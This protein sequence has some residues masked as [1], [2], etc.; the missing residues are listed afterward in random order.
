VL[1]QTGGCYAR[2]GNYKSP[3]E[4]RAE[5]MEAD[6]AREREA[7]ERLASAEL[8]MEFQAILAEP[9]G[10]A[11]QGLFAALNNYEKQATGITKQVALRTAFRASRGLPPER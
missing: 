9:A 2:P 3:A 10:A 1:R 7:S 8:E 6:L 5:A 4:L 11:Y